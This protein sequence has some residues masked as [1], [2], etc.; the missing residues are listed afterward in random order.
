MQL[1]ISFLLY[2]D[3]R[4]R[5][6]RCKCEI[7]GYDCGEDDGEGDYVLCCDAVWTRR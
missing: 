1:S 7:P 3:P 4:I 6:R 5:T 2:G